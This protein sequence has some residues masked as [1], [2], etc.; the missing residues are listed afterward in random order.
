M[1]VW[2]VRAPQ[3]ARLSVKAH[4]CDV[5]AISWNRCEQH[6]LVS[7]ADDGEF[8][9]W[10]LRTFPG[11]AQGKAVVPVASFKS[12]RICCVRNSP[13]VTTCLVCVLGA[14]VV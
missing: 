6:L 14:P 9:V 5:N 11:A 2:D 7:G 13:V 10:D 8:R 12:D 4:D 1:R 3:T